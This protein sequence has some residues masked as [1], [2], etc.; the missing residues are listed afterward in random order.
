MGDVVIVAYRP[1]PGCEQAL[2]ALARTH[3]PFLRGLGLATNR[4]E[5]LLRATDGTILEVFEWRDGGIEAAHT[6]PKMGAL[7]GQYAALCTYVPLRELPETADMFAT[8]KP[9]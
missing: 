8:F 6:H 2:E 5:I 1:L 7:W 9:I 4:P 3:V